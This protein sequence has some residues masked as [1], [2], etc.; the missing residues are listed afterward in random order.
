MS[1]THGLELCY[2]NFDIY[3]PTHDSLQLLYKKTIEI[4]NNN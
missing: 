3:Y 2:N 1:L 4:L